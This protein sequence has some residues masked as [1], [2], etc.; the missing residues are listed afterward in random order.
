MGGS[1]KSR[2]RLLQELETVDGD[3]M[4]GFDRAAERRLYQQME[5]LVLI[6]PIHRLNLTPML[7]AYMNEI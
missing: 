7:N 1:A 5:R 6:C 3:N 4:R 2:R